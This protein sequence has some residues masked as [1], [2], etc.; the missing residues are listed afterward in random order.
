MDIATWLAVDVTRLE[1]RWDIALIRLVGLIP[2]A[3]FTSDQGTEMSK[4]K[5]VEL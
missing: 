1:S 5:S 3:D 4:Y 2:G